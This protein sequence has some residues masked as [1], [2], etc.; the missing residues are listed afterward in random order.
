[1]ARRDSGARYV[2]CAME[3]VTVSPV[4]GADERFVT[5]AERHARQALDLDAEMLLA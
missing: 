2:R 5:M 3:S 1:M 4:R